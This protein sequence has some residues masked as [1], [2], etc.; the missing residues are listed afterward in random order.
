MLCI[1]TDW[2]QEGLTS[3][4]NDRTDDLRIVERQGAVMFEPDAKHPFPRAFPI[5][6]QSFPGRACSARVGCAP[7]SA[8][9]PL[10][11]SVE[12]SPGS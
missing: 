2:R 6:K 8:R 11:E 9:Q 5:A 1:G 4:Q 12:E 7:E 10:R 3:G